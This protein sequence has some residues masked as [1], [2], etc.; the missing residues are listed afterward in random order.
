MLTNNKLV[1]NEKTKVTKRQI[2]NIISD[3]LFNCGIVK[4]KK[5]LLNAFLD[6]EKEFSTGVGDGIA[7]PHAA[8][9]GIDHPIVSVV[10]VKD[11]DWKSID[12]KPVTAIVAIIVPKDGRN[13]HMAILTELSRKMVNSDFTNKIKKSPIKEV[14]ELINSITINKEQKEENKLNNKNTKYVIGITACPTGIAHTFMAQ[15]KIIDS[16]EAK[17]YSVKVETQG[18]DGVKNK[19]TIDD[20]NNADAI[21]I[22]TGIELDGMER[23]NGYEGKI[24]NSELQNTIANGPKVVDEAIELGQNFNS[25]SVG[26]TATTNSVTSFTSTEK[27]KWDIFMGHIMSGVSAM[28][29]ILLIAGLLMAIGNIGAL[30]WTLPEKAH[31]GAVEFAGPDYNIW[32]NLMYYFNQIGSIVMKFMYPIFAMALARSIGGKLASIPG[33]MGGVMAAGL[34]TSFMPSDIYSSPLLSWAYP[35]GFIPSMFFGAMI[36][37][38][39]VGVL[40]NFLN[41]K[42]EFGPKLI[43]LKTMLLIPLIMSISVFI[44]MAFLVNPLFGQVNYWLQKGFSAAGTSGALLYQMSIAFGTAFD[45]GGPFNKAAGAIANGMN[46]DAFDAFTTAINSGVGIDEAVNSLQTF[47]LTS[48]TLA[49]IIPP[50]GLGLAAMFGNSITR[51]N[52]FTKEDQQVGGQA[53][54]LGLIAISEGGIPFLIKYPLY[55]ITADVIGSMVAS[56]VA[57]LF[58][59]IQTLPLP[60]VWGWFLTGTTSI[61]GVEYGI[62]SLGQQLSGYVISIIIGVVITAS[63]FIMFMYAADIRKDKANKVSNISVIKNSKNP[64]EIIEKS[65]VSINNIIS[66]LNNEKNSLTIKSDHFDKVSDEEITKLKI[67][68]SKIK[69]EL[70][71]E[72]SKLSQHHY[73]IN[74]FKAKIRNIN[75]KLNNID[76]KYANKINSLNNEI[77]KYNSWI[78]EREKAIVDEEIK[79]NSFI[80]QKIDIL[81]RKQ[82]ELKKYEK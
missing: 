26:L 57:V 80:N 64:K 20:I 36:V 46:T 78:V 76:K 51:R 2:L 7:I 72:T 42:I 77:D 61:S 25:S 65:S 38:F 30:A 69:V 55:V 74:H 60:A 73:K 63:I 23:F 48:R 33:F 68:F 29:P 9:D 10:R 52:I 15:Q 56:I 21:I 18:S 6:R 35:N 14:V 53:T 11:I 1:F 3:K 32:V 8:I 43:T 47:N 75:D 16:A 40:T 79:V 4:D 81:K 54:F 62:A 59:S 27:T 50:I 12:K 19:L 28:I 13:D 44:F 66:F 41:K 58:G 31:I 17:G 37:G 39:F 49:I 71:K 22:S 82:K 45:L 34:E 24:Y 67:S 70:S 5:E